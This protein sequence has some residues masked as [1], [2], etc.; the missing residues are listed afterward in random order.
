M[1]IAFSPFK[2]RNLE[3][4]NH[5]MRSSTNEQKSD[6]EG[7]P[8][9]EIKDMIIKLSEGHIGLIV[10]GFMYVN[11]KGKATENQAGMYSEELAK[12]WISTVE[13]VH[14]NGSKILVQLTHGGPG[15]VPP[16]EPVSAGERGRKLTIEEIKEIE[17]WF[18]QA[19]KYCEEAGFDGIQLGAGHGYLLST[20]LSPITNKR[21]DEYGGS[22]ENNVRMVSNIAQGI[23]KVTN[24]NFVIGI[25]LNGTDR[26]EGGVTPEIASRYVTLLK[27][28]FDFFEISS[29]FGVAKHVIQDV[30]KSEAKQARPSRGE[31]Y[32]I[33]AA[34][35]IKKNNPDVII[36]GV[37]GV[38]TKVFIDEVLKSKKV[39]YISMARPFLE[40]PFYLNKLQ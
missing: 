23:R 10:T 39:D 36:T 24:P 28:K 21:T 19:A 35:L 37:G 17:G 31:G 29:G 13:K 34:S 30:E 22:D 16:L 26:A 27:D 25:K 18:I 8:T 1:S 20:F 7:H 12:E 5:F 33:E 6:D 14:Q 2:I 15:V 40:D 11:P 4:C 38:R 32:N 9:Q 3:L